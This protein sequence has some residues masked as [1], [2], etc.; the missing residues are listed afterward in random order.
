MTPVLPFLNRRVRSGDAPNA[1]R[2]RRSASVPAA[3][4]L[5]GA[6]MSF[7]PPL[8]SS[9]RLPGMTVFAAGFALVFASAVYFFAW[10]WYGLPEA[11]RFLLTG[12]SSALC[13]AL[14]FLAE[15]KGRRNAAA[16]ALLG[17]AL[18]TGIFWVTFGQIFQSGATA[19]ELCL[20]WAACVVPLF[21][22][23]R[24]ASLW[25]LLVVLLFTASCVRPFPLLLASFR[26]LSLVPPLITAAGC[27]AL[28]LFP[29]L[30][31]RCPCGLH[32]CLALP[33]TLLTASATALSVQLILFYPDT[34][35]LL[36]E[37]ATGPAAL[38]LVLAA[39]LRFRHAL[40]LSEAALALV[41]LLN[42]LIVRGFD[43]LSS[44][45]LAFLFTAA[46]ILFTF[47]LA[48]ALPRLRQKNS[49]RPLSPGLC[50]L[51]PSILGGFLAA[52]SFI[53]LLTLTFLDNAVALHS[54][55]LAC[56]AGGIVLWRRRRTH[57]FLS[58]LSSALV[59]GGSLCFHLSLFDY[60]FPVITASVWA[61]ALFIYL[62]MN[63]PI[64]RFFAVFWAL[65][66]SLVLLPQSVSEDVPLYLLFALLLF[67]PL[68]AAA[69][70]RFP[71]R[72]LRPAALAC[73]C[74]FPF[75]PLTMPDP[76]FKETTER[77]LIALAALNLAILLLR[78]LFPPVSAPLPRPGKLA[79]VIAA[80]L[81]VWFFSPLESLFAL[82]L[83]FAGVTNAPTSAEGQEAPAFD[84][85][86]TGMGI[87]I[88]AASL[89]LFYYAIDHCFPLETMAMAV[90]ETET[91][92]LNM[93]LAAGIPGLCLLFLGMLMERRPMQ[94][95][96]EK[97]DPRPLPSLLRHGLP[98][99]L[100]AAL[101][102]AVAC[103]AIV[104]RKK[105]LQTGD[106]ILLSLRPRDPRA[107]MIG[108]YMDLT[109]DIERSSSVE[110]PLCM[111]LAVD[112][113][114][115]ARPIPDGIKQGDCTGVPAPAV[116]VD[117]PSH[118][119]T[120]LRLP[121]RYYFEQGLARVYA[122]AAF[123]VLRCDRNNNCLLKGLADADRR[124]L[125]PQRK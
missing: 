39:A 102:T 84:R 100:I 8:P 104:D 87:V 48:L 115:I 79:S 42:A 15:R 54:A 44:P 55:G 99:A 116:L 58:V 56:M 83:I 33:L 93:S 12:G 69:F 86:L 11:V 71:R 20:V 109:Y 110:G 88:L 31:R 29:P 96:P 22:M 80:I 98:F 119:V 16:L 101:M 105:L 51:A 32:A 61:A 82:N 118:G 70:G 50:S 49:R 3:T 59:S 43:H 117:T 63:S 89:V 46:N 68:I 17:S 35:L 122:D 91:H 9:A 120:R 6:S 103:T 97:P 92:F 14:S 85:V 52:L 10:N 38:A 57:I 64:P 18:L 95:A 78:Q 23:R 75:L 25:N 5:I 60:A 74:F 28:A 107:F 37:A 77:I 30:R 53:V 72:M 1:S 13:L 124:P 19:W 121:H 76:A 2:V 108:D 73:L 41:V 24:N 106:E 125:L 26:E 47:L 36:P 4:R 114:G 45:A 27:C 7:L 65:V 21:L 112:E 81:P 90:M 66:T 67:L 40:A 34:N 111:P 123:A 113:L 62:L 94:E